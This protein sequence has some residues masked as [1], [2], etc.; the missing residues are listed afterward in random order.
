VAA[1]K[2]DLMF[3]SVGSPSAA[4]NGAAVKLSATLK[5]QGTAA[6]PASMVRWYLSSDST[7]TSS[8]LPLA[9]L[10]T[11]ALAAGATRTLSV[12]VGIPLDVPAGTYTIGAIADPDNGVGESSDTNNARASGTKLVVSYTVDLV[13]TAV[14]G[15]VSAV[16]G[17]NVTFTGTLKNQG[18]AAAGEVVVGFYLSSSSSISP[19]DR[20][21][22]S[23][24]VASLAG[25]AS[26]AVS[27]TAAL[28]TDLPAGSYYIGAI[29]D[30]AN[31]VAESNNA[32]NSRMAAGLVSTSY[33]P[34]LVVSSVSAPASGT[35]GSAI[36]VSATVLNQGMGAIGMASDQAVITKGSTLRVGIY[37]SRNATITTAD[38]LVGTATFSALGAGASM[39]LNLNVTLPANLAAGAYYIGAIADRSREL[40]ETIEV[41]NALAGNLITVR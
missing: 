9:S 2:V 35:R 7:I 28:R 19:S 6:A 10:S 26:V 15:P 41:N 32:N 13:M 31:L 38:E 36:A 4:K 39:P 24:K 18:A 12:S 11:T 25:G 20:L 33:G 1:S 16:T 17:Q 29:A 5:N 3:T 30:P 27:A 14:A 22:A 21:I 37:L 34:D 40:R 23:T 8:D